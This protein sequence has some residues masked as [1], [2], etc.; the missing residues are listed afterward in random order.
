MMNFQFYVLEATRKN[1][2]RVMNG[3]TM[4]QLNKI[5]AGFNNNLI[6]NFG[7]VIVTQQLLN[8]A[9]SGLPMDLSDDLVNKY[10]KGSKP[11][12]IVSEA[13]YEMLKT[14][15]FDLIETLKKDYAAGIFNAYKPYTTSYNTTLTSI[16]EAINFNNVHEALHLGLVMAM[17]KL[18]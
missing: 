9:L 16:E 5:P 10:R 18:V 2:L 12:L 8:Y 3:L 14:V 15:A 1:M 7:H 4:D 11:D 13:E 17:Q 6:W